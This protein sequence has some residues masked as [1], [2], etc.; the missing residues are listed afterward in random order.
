MHSVFEIKQTKN[1]KKKFILAL[2]TNLL[3]IDIVLFYY[4]AFEWWYGARESSLERINREAASVRGYNRLRWERNDKENLGAINSDSE[5]EVLRIDIE[6]EEEEDE[7]EEGDTG[8]E[9]VEGECK[10]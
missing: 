2:I 4:A 5:K 7:G 1:R 9:V 6:E 10:C 3:E 8:D